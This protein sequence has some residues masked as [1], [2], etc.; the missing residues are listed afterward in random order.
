MTNG[1]V[2]LLGDA[3]AARLFVVMECLSYGFQFNGT[4]ATETSLIERLTPPCT[5]SRGRMR[6]LPPPCGAVVSTIEFDAG[7]GTLSLV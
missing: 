2:D 4:C 3:I 1:V 6:E 5:K 7:V